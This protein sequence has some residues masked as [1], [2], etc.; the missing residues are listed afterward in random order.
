MTKL[1]PI[2]TELSIPL[3]TP[4]NSTELTEVR[5]RH[6]RGLTLTDLPLWLIQIKT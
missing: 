3:K 4:S 5:P 2:T 1:T 6:T